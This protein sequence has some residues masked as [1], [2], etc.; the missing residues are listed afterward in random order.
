M[1]RRA[2]FLLAG[3]LPRF[4]ANFS[5]WVIRRESPIL[6]KQIPLLLNTWNSSPMQSPC[7]IAEQISPIFMASWYSSCSSSRQS[8]IAYIAFRYPMLAPS[9]RIWKN[10]WTLWIGGFVLNRTM[11]YLAF[12]KSLGKLFIIL[13]ALSV[14][15][16]SPL[17]P[18]P[19]FLASCHMHRKSPRSAPFLNSVKS[20]FFSSYS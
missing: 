6:L 13:R 4:A 14:S 7:F 9:T 8:P 15:I 11:S 16:I 3:P 19:K 2:I 5:H 18:Y 20:M 10:F 17:N 1:F 12:G